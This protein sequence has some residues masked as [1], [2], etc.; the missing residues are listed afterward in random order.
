MIKNVF[1]RGPGAVRQT[2][3]GRE[4]CGDRSRVAGCKCLSLRSCLK[5]KETM[6]MDF[7][8]NEKKEGK[9]K[10]MAGGECCKTI[11]LFQS[12]VT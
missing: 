10:E 9:R 3:G 1:G 8:R 12:V 6:I 4:R 5:M 2:K 7:S 11:S